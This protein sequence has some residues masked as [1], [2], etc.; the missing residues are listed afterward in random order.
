MKLIAL[1]LVALAVGLAPITTLAFMRGAPD[2]FVLVAP[3]PPPACKPTH[4]WSI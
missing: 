2:R 1:I 4:L 3:A